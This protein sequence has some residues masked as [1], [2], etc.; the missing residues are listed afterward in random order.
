MNLRD[1][2]AWPAIREAIKREVTST[3]DVHDTL[4]GAWLVPADEKAANA[5]LDL[6]ATAALR[7]MQKAE[8]DAQRS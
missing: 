8:K 6:M 5:I 2:P 4:D 3:A 1:H 7:A